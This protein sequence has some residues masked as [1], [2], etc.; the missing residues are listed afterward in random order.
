MQSAALTRSTRT[1]I[2][3]EEILQVTRAP[4][5]LKE[6]YRKAAKTL[7]TTAYSTVFR[8][9]QKLEEDGRVAKVSWRDRGASYEW[10]DRPHHHHL[11]CEKC[12]AIEDVPDTSMCYDESK[13]AKA[14]GYLITHHS[15][16]LAGVCKPCQR[17][18][19]IKT[20]TK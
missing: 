8:I 17:N 12:E 2:K 18:K 15:I 13:V 4:L 7:P 3:I 11:V 6:L 20:K 19:K 16:E 1:K 5:T 10:T 14:T 9:I